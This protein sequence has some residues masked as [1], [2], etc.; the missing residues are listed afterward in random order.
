MRT[1]IAS[2]VLSL[3]LVACKPPVTELQIPTVASMQGKGYQEVVPMTELKASAGSES[4]TAFMIMPEMVLINTVEQLQAKGETKDLELYKQ[5]ILGD[6]QIIC[7]V[8]IQAVSKTNSDPTKWTFSLTDD[9]GKKA[10][11]KPAGEIGPPKPIQASSGQVSFFQD[12]QVKFEGYKIGTAKKISIQFSREGGKPVTLTWVVP[13]DHQVPASTTPASQPT[14][15]A[16]AP[17]KP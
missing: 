17:A 5:K 2:F 4:I 16:S 1:L 14:P 6:D 9:S 13:A 12:A 8:R 7:Q 15:P 3:S 11:G 10:T